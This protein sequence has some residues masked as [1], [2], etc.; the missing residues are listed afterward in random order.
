MRIP[1]S[2]LIGCMPAGTFFKTVSS[3]AVVLFILTGTVNGDKRG[4]GRLTILAGAETHAMRYPCDCPYTPGGGL[5]QRSIIIDSVRA[6]GDHVLLLDAGGFAAGGVYDTYTRGAKADS[7]RTHLTLRSMAHMGY[8]AVCIGDEELQHDIA[9]LSAVADSINVPLISANCF[10]SDGSRAFPAYIIK[11]YGNMR[12]AITAVTTQERFLLRSSNAAQIRITEPADALRQLIDSL[13]NLSD[14]R[15][16]LS[17]CG[18]RM[19][20]MLADSLAGYDLFVNGHRKSTTRPLLRH[21]GKPVMQ[22]GFQ[23][24]WLSSITLR[25][26]SGVLRVIDSSMCT[27]DTSRGSD[28]FVDE[29]LHTHDARIDSVSRMLFDLYMMGQCPYGIDALKEYTEFMRYREDAPLRTRI[30]FIGSVADDGSLVSLHGEQEVQEEMYWLAVRECE[31]DKWHRFLYLRAHSSGPADSLAGILQLDTARIAKWVRMHGDS[32]LRMHYLRS[33]RLGI[34]ASPTLLVNNSSFEKPV[35][36]QHMISRACSKGM[37]SDTLCET[38]PECSEDADCVREGMAGVCVESD[39]EAARCKYLPARACTLTV[40]IAPQMLT[41]AQ[42]PVIAHMQR[43]FPGL[44]VRSIPLDSPGAEKLRASYTIEALPWYHFGKNIENTVRFE[45]IE[46]RLEPRKEGYVFKP[47]AVNR[48]LFLTQKRVKNDIVLAVDPLFPQIDKVLESISPFF[49]RDNGHTFHIQPLVMTDPTEK[50]LAP[51]QRIRLEI[52]GRW[53][54]MQNDYR[55]L[56]PKYLR[57]YAQQPGS[58]S[59]IGVLDSMGISPGRFTRISPECERTLFEWWKRERALRMQGPVHLLVENR[60]RID[61]TGV[62]Q[63]RSR[64][65]EVFSHFGKK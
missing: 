43:L 55:D 61:I 48:T 47:G 46:S 8:D 37:L 2:F 65:Q 41:R 26:D 62:E 22:F 13:K 1:P 42:Q 24:K 64:V 58:H 56:F 39:T 16:V 18:E 30:W 59:W 25:Q 15:I 6:T 3:V 51:V 33:T 12:I 4:P 52:A 50:N 10:L 29:L 34:T 32:V 9:R 11:K 5:A 23:G 21:A 49:R 28:P 54:R 14:Y 38:M 63:L 57:R 45:Q 27:V 40:L 44:T 35:E 17:H 7:L 60:E 20:R 53:C 36:A 19:T 31:P